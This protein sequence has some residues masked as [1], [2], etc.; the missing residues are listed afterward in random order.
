VF[1]FANLLIGVGMLLGSILMLV[2][3]TI[4]VS[5]VFSWLRVG[6]NHPIVLGINSVAYGMFAIIKKYFKRTE[7]WSMDFAPLITLLLV[8]F[9]DTVLSDTLVD[10]GTLIKREAV[11]ESFNESKLV[12][13]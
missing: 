1:L 13:E 6:S 2:Q 3:I 5:F 11:L 8:L 10:Y 9:I 7:F 4:I 12:S